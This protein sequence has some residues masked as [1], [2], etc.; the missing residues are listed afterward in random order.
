MLDNVDNNKY[1]NILLLQSEFV[2]ILKDLKSVN[3]SLPSNQPVSKIDL[4]SVLFSTNGQLTTPIEE[5]KAINLNPTV[6]IIKNKEV[7]AY[8]ESIVKFSCLEGIAYLTAHSMVYIGQNDYIPTGYL[9]FYFYTKSK[10][11]L[12]NTNHLKYSSDPDIDSKKDY[13]IDKIEFLTKYC[14]PNSILLIDGPLIGGDVYTYMIRAINNFLEKNIIPIFF[15]KNSSSN[16]VTD[17]IS[18]LSNKYNSDL[19]WAYRFLNS[20]QRTNFF[21]YTDKNNPNNSKIFCYLKCFDLSPQRVEFHIDTFKAYREEIDKILDMVYY[22][23]LVQGDKQN[24]QVRPIAI[25]EKF[26][27]EFIRLTDINKYFYDFGLMPTMNQERFGW[28]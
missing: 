20:G 9:T 23:L 15:V 18:D 5:I 6:N 12:Q 14:P 7:V 28:K 8:D 13:I 1:G 21:K 4:Q 3:I 25:A 2:D 19:H 27:R 16:L 10:D 24:P 11:I 17:S 22:L 26:A